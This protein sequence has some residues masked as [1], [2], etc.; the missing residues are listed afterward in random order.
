MI[1]AGGKLPSEEAWCLFSPNLSWPCISLGKFLNSWYPGIWPWS[2]LLSPV[3]RGTWMDAHNLFQLWP[4]WPVTRAVREIRMWKHQESSQ[5]KTT[6]TSKVTGR[7]KSPNVLHGLRYFKHQTL[8]K[9]KDLI[10]LLLGIFFY[11]QVLI[12]KKEKP[13]RL[14]ISLSTQIILTSSGKLHRIS[15]VVRLNPPSNFKSQDVFQHHISWWYLLG[16][17]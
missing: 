2:S 14:C 9:L 3:K 13:R 11:Y 1:E 7:K 5:S 8:I 16:F 4:L 17:K 12:W 6:G 10:P 15:W